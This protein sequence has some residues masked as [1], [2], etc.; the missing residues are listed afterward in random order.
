VINAIPC[1]RSFLTDFLLLPSGP[2]LIDKYQPD[3]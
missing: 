1:S 2:E 3:V